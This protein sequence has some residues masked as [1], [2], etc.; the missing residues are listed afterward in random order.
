MVP[1]EFEWSYLPSVRFE[2]AYSVSI[3]RGTFSCNAKSIWIEADEIN[4]FINELEKIVRGGDGLASLGCMSNFFRFELSRHER[5][6]RS[7]ILIKGYNEQGGTSLDTTSTIEDYGLLS[8]WH[9]DLIRFRQEHL[10]RPGQE[11]E[12][13]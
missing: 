1:T 5:Q 9:R 8:K 4:R 6:V 7:R 12:P 2:I 10:T 11:L 13:A 3:S